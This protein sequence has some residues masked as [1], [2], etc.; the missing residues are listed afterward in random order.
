M[1][2]MSFALPVT[3]DRIWLVLDPGGWLASHFSINHVP[4]SHDSASD[5]MS[6][7]T[8]PLSWS[9][10]GFVDEEGRYII[11]RPRMI[12][13]GK[14]VLVRLCW[15]EIPLIAA[16]AK[17]GPSGQRQYMALLPRVLSH[18]MLGVVL[19]SGA[20]KQTLHP[21]ACTREARASK[22]GAFHIPCV[23]TS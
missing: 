12:P 11:L 20:G 7:T 10:K 17:I 19:K 6:G 21:S 5:G 2:Q 22:Y 13:E 23:E 3:N 9:S 15:F 14:V 18:H 4:I 16:N 1:V 8:N